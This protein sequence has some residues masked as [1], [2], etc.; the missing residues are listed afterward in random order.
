VR[1]AV[2]PAVLAVLL[3]TGCSVEPWNYL[4]EDQKRDLRD[5][6]SAYQQA[7]LED[8]QVTED[9][10]RQAVEDQRDCVAA[11]GANADEISSADRRNLSFAYS[12]TAATEREAEVIQ[13]TTDTCLHEFVDTVGRIWASQ[14]TRL[15][16]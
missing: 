16:E 2:A 15:T 10:Y 9:E 13:R 7:V 11:A 3:L 6:T 1:P 12:F 5:N 4:D 8:L 14:G